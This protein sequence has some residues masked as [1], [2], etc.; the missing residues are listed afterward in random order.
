MEFAS[1]VTAKTAVA[2]ITIA[3]LTRVVWKVTSNVLFSPI[4]SSVPGPFIARLTTKWILLVDLSGSRAR[5]VHELHKKYGPVVRLAPNELSFA[6]LQ[7]VKPVYGSGTTCIK[8]SAYDN[9]GRLGSFQMRDPAQ[10]RERQKRVAHVFAQS[11]LQQMEPLIQG[12]VDRLIGVIGQSLGK[13]VDALHWCRMTALDISGEVLMG[14][15]FGAFDANGAAPTY[16]HHLDNAY[17][18]WTLFGLAPLLCN[19]LGRLPVK[20]MQQFF[21]AGDYVYQYGDDALK[22]YL[23]LYG[24]SSKRRSLLTK[25]IQGDPSTGTEPLTDPEI[26]VEVSNLVFAAT[27]TTGNTMTYALYRLCCHPKW[28][29]KLRAEIRASGAKAG[30]FSFQL[31]QSLPVLNGIVM[32]TLRLHP[33]AP[34]FTTQRDPKYFPD[35]DSFTPTRWM[36][37]SGEINPGTPEMREMMLVWGK[38][39]RACLGQHMAVMEIKILLARMMDRFKVDMVPQTHAEMEMTDHF[40]LIPKGQRCTLIFS[41]AD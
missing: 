10:H 36:T 14:K 37:E 30:N 24:R 5:T 28:Q 20:S 13:Q 2:A 29:E 18:V 27:D 19:V 26:S 39:A 9:F 1:C 11:S 35:P 33:A 22:E 8:S 7:A 23:K 40:T 31:L 38:G 15:S 25:I 3:L 17:L 21:D 41:N 34:T 4:P 32:E 16:V 6:A 12:V